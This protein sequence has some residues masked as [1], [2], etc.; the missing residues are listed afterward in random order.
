MVNAGAIVV[1][2]L[3]KVQSNTCAVQVIKEWESWRYNGG[4][5]VNESQTTAPSY[6]LTQHGMTT[7]PQIPHAE[8]L[9]HKHIPCMGRYQRS[10]EQQNTDI[11]VEKDGFYLVNIYK[12]FGLLLKPRTYWW[13]VFVICVGKF[14]MLS[15]PISCCMSLPVHWTNRALI[16]CGSG[17]VLHGF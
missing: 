11:K 15:S 2:S 1:S 4:V 13:R 9:Q 3:I 14:S 5:H 17:S 7:I 8:Y 10:T 16:I 12:T 6:F